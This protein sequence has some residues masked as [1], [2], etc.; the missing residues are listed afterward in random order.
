MPLEPTQ[1]LLASDDYR[2]EA[3]VKSVIE[4]NI[5][6]KLFIQIVTRN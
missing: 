1:W 3:K 4:R 5:C 2:L 6:S